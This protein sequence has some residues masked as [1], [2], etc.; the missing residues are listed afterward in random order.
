MADCQG[1]DSM[2]TVN[3]VRDSVI[4]ALDQSFP[5]IK[6]YGEEI[7]QGFEEP[8]FFVKLFPVSQDQII[9]RRYLRNHAFDIHYFAKTNEALHDMADQLYDKMELIGLDDGLARGTKMRHEIV[10]CVLHFFVNYNF[11]VYKESDVVDPMEILTVNN[12][13]KGD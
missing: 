13:L 10:D 5:D 1:D 6:K 8:C 7:K 3:A 12:N 4:T 11:H 9:G 2:I